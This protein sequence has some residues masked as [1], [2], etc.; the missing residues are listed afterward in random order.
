[1]LVGGGTESTNF[2]TTT[3]AYQT[4]NNTMGR[5]DGFISIISADEK[6]INRYQQL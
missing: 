2:P 1:M 5:S 6:H 3:G 4:S